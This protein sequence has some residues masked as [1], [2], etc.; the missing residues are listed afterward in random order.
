[1]E[2]KK[3]KKNKKQYLSLLLL[4]DEQENMIYRYLERGDMYALFDHDLKTV[5]VVTNEGNGVFELK[6]IATLPQYQRMGYG[7]LL[8]DYISN[9]YK[10]KGTTLTVGT[11]DSPLTI[12]FY[13]ACGFTQSHRLKN[14][15][16]DNYDRP[17]FECGKQLIDMVYFKKVL[18][19]DK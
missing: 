15:I 6:N 10:N 8:I 14:F 2:I 7:K 19:N 1:M 16:L 11:G 3:I 5:C 13:E 18:N 9:E 17:I 4:A 12:S